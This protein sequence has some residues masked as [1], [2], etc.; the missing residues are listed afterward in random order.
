MCVT[1]TDKISSC[2][3]HMNRFDSRRPLAGSTDASKDKGR[4]K[5]M[6]QIFVTID[7]GRSYHYELTSTRGRK[8]MRRRKS[9]KMSVT[10]DEMSLR[11]PP[12]WI[13]LPRRRI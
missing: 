9:C 10:M 7:D 6:L 1:M 4:D 12:T 11:Q 13:Y 5:D 8:R 2:A 3:T